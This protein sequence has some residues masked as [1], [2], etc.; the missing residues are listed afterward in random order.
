M[1][2]AG[3]EVSK[4][5]ASII[6]LDDNFNSIVK[7]ILWGRNVYDSI[8]KFLQF[9][10]TVNI[11]AVVVT[12]M[13]AAILQFA[14]LTAVQ[15]LW[16]N[17]IM[18]TL[19]SLALATEP[20]RD[21]LLNKKPHGKDDYIISKLMMKHILGQAIYQIIIMNIIIFAGDLWIPEYLTPSASFPDFAM[22]SNSMSSGTKYVRSGREFMMNGVDLDYSTA[23]LDLYGPTRHFT[24]VFNTFVFLQIFNFF[25]CRK[26]N[27]EF[28]IFENITES[29]LFVFIVVAICAGQLIL[30]NL[31]GIALN[32]SPNAMDGR[33]W[34]ICWA[35]SSGGLIVNLLLKLI[36]FD[37][38]LN[39]HGM[40]MRDPLAHTSRILNIKRTSEE[41]LNRK[42]TNPMRTGSKQNSLPRVIHAAQ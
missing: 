10:L 3:T 22:Y 13:N 34:L 42:Y 33:Q 29:P 5:A 14:V 26:L 37:K 15:L 31:G 16:V 28:N 40:E 30:G 21:E 17:L 20:P 11:V 8:R 4:E 27:D 23:M 36:P 1:G 35:L 38:C 19:A 25:S 9:Q 6:L 7:A 18:D 39:P 41:S 12:L 24:F 2:I 32:V